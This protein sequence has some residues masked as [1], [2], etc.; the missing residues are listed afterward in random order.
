VVVRAGRLSWNRGLVVAR[1][2]GMSG[3]GVGKWL[4]G[5]CEQWVGGLSEG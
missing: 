3:H 4:R 5:R 2:G 1:L